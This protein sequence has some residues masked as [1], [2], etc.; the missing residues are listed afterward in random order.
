MLDAAA[1]G[2]PLVVSDRM[3]ERERVNG[4]GAV[5]CEDDVSDL[6][7]VLRTLAPVDVRRALGAAGRAKMVEHFS[8]RKLARAIEADYR[9]SGAP[10]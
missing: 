8:W 10:A 6:A 4:N 2:L 3:G 5:F 9:A 1:S 7:A